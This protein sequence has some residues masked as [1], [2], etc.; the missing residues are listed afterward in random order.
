[1]SALNMCFVCMTALSIMPVNK[2][3]L[4]ISF[5]DPGLLKNT[6]HPQQVSSIS[7]DPGSVVC[8]F[9]PVRGKER[10]H[11]SAAHCVHKE[12]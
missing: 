12:Y 3:S 11:N 7:T 10:E 2:M 8:S 5:I 9:T 4:G 6:T 1:M